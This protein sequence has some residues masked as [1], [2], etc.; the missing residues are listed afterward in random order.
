MSLQPVIENAVKHGLRDKLLTITIRAYAKNDM[1]VIEIEDNG[2]GLNE[3]QAFE[4][5]RRIGLEEERSPQTDKLA[6][7]AGTPTQGSGIGLL[8]VQRRIRMHYGREYGLH[9]ESH[10]GLY[11]RIVI[12]IPHI[13]LSGGVS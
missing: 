5:N 3:E 4:L 7:T 9:I 8:N 10:E 12:Q 1:M 2:A 6:H 13:I 11:T